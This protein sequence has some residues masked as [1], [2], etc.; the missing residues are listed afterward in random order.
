MLGLKKGDVTLYPYCQEWEK[1]FQEEAGCI[2]SLIGNSVIAIEHIVST[3]IP[4]MKA[5][6][7][8]DLMIAFESMKMAYIAATVLESNGYVRR[9]N[10]DLDDRVFLVKGEESRRTH[11]ISLTSEKSR[12]WIDHIV[13]RNQLR[14]NLPLAAEYL[15][16]KIELAK[17]HK[18]NRY[19]YTSAKE[20]F[21]E[22]CNQQCARLHN[23]FNPYRN[24][25]LLH[26]AK[27]H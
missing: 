4:A 18:G 11:H 15:K 17:K 1:Y 27:S 16:L 23:M 25:A 21:I 6:P 14:N 9:L 2:S 12:F 8:I 26:A 19:E 5:K 10:G 24:M 13:F 20:S 3:S 7:I 22:C